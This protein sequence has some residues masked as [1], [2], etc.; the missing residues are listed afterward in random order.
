MASSSSSRKEF[1]KS[2]KQFMDKHGFDGLD[3]DWEYPHKKDRDSL[4]ALVKEMRQE[5]D[6]SKGI[7]ITVPIRKCESSPYC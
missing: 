2:A 4:T 3:I 7:S 1:I 5:F 6:S